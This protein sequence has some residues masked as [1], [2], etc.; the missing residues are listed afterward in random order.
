LIGEDVRNAFIA[1]II[2]TVLIT[3]AAIFMPRAKVDEIAE[4]TTQN[5]IVANEPVAPTADP[6]RRVVDMTDEQMHLVDALL[7]LVP[8]GAFDDPAAFER[9]FAQRII[10]SCCD[11]MNLQDQ[12]ESLIDFDT[13]GFPI[14]GANI[15]ITLYLCR[16]CGTVQ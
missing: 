16:S 9:E 7:R 2:L 11:D 14:P 10:V 15:N 8:S 1:I 3:S 5:D 12:R 6:F 4:E 13:N